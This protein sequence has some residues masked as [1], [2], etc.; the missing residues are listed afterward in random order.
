MRLEEYIQTLKGFDPNL[1]LEKGLSNPHSWR[2]SYDQLSF[3]IVDNITIGEMLK[4][5]EGCIGKIFYGW[6]GGEYLMDQYSQINVE[7]E[8]GKCSSGATL[9]SWF[10][11]L[12]IKDAEA[13]Q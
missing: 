12:L 4:V 6:K 1:K 5:A 9:F 3:E 10:L 7:V 13:N 11:E 8:S 2:G